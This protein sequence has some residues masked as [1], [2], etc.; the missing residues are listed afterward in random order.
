MATFAGRHFSFDLGHRTYVMG[1]LNVT[2]DSF[3]DGGLWLAPD[4]AAH[5]AMKMQEAGA[6]II[7]IGA[8]STRP[9]HVPVSAE[10]ELKR[11]LPILERLKGRIA[12][13]LSID[14]YYPE[15]A[16][17]AL[18]SGAVIIND[19]G[20]IA[21]PEMAEVVR[22]AG[23]G[24]VVMHTGGAD[25]ASVADYPNDDVVAAVRSF[26]VATA[27]TLAAAGLPPSVIC[28]DPGIG[29]GKTHAHNLT[30]LRDTA[31][32]HLPEHAL[33]T[34]ASRKRVVALASGEQDAARRLPGS[35]AAHTAAIAGGTDILRVHDVAESVQAA[36]VAD[37]IYRT[38]GF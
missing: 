33:L 13:P 11:L 28:F 23:A 17:A 4:D 29:F 2:P 36:R 16:A 14:T 1:I 38:R 27:R 32:V 19:V 35:I 24:W 12:V 22:K 34:G 31:K 18:A 9:G 10:E 25:A 6:D 5:H 7:D 30:L 26:F 21:S 20:G 3:S 15:V 8:Q 37:A